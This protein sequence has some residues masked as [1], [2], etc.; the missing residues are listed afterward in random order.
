MFTFFQQSKAVFLRN[1]YWTPPRLM[2]IVNDIIFGELGDG[3][4]EV[5]F[6]PYLLET[7][8]LDPAVEYTSRDAN[9][10]FYGRVL[11]VNKSRLTD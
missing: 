10:P 1:G 3:L 9:M 11:A 8:L 4:E 6:T 2:N 7:V 5:S